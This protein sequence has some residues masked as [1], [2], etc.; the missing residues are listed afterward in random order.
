MVPNPFVDS[1]WMENN[2][3]F[4]FVFSTFQGK[5]AFCIYKINIKCSDFA[6]QRFAFLIQ[7][8]IAYKCLIV[9]FSCFILVTS[10]TSPPVIAPA[11][12]SFLLDLVTLYFVKVLLPELVAIT[13]GTVG[14]TK[15][16]V[17]GLA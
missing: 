9:L 7:Y 2:F 15:C 6:L 1:L 5:V 4:G 16:V 17:N 8:W 13:K 12:A 3:C 10:F 14:R 11:A